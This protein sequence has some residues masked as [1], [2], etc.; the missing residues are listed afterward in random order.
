MPYSSAGGEAHE[1]R[2]SLEIPGY[3]LSSRSNTYVIASP[4][5]HPQQEAVGIKAA[6]RSSRRKLS[7]QSYD[8]N[9]GKNFNYVCLQTISPWS[10]GSLQ[11]LSTVQGPGN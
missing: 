1:T 3:D 11:C 7:S 10:L 2:N 9:I 4:A 6:H 5:Q 8:F